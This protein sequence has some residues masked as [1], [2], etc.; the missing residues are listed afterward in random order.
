MHG[1]ITPPEWYG[2]VILGVLAHGLINIVRIQEAKNNQLQNIRGI[3]TTTA[4]AL[5]RGPHAR[6]TSI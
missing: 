2:N 5:K 6:Q 1:S 4:N 3:P